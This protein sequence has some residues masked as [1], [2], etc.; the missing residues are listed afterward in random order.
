MIGRKTAAATLQHPFSF[1][2]EEF[3]K[4]FKRKGRKIPVFRAHLLQYKYDT[5]TKIAREKSYQLKP[6]QHKSIYP[7]S[8]L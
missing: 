7:N 8:Q 4:V 5:V 3:R 2:S 1:K 6:A